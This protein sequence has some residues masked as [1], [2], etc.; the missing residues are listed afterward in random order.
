MDAALRSLVHAITAVDEAR[1]VAAL[2]AGASVAVTRGYSPLCHATLIGHEAIVLAVLQ[3]RPDVNAV[4]RHGN[5]ALH[6]AVMGRSVA[7]VLLLLRHG[8]SPNTKSAGGS[9]PLH[10]AARRGQTDIVSALL[11]HGALVNVRDRD[12]FTPLALAI[13]RGHL[14]VVHLLLRTEG[15]D[16]SSMSEAPLASAVKSRRLDIARAL[17]QHGA[18]ASAGKQPPLFYAVRAGDLDM[19][20]LLLEFGADARARTAHGFTLLHVAVHNNH[21]NIVAQLVKHG[22]LTECP[23]EATRSPD[24]QET[25]L[26]LARRL[27][28]N[29]IVCILE[30]VCV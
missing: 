25:L 19:V 22:A 20:S 8:A 5:V 27:G 26:A 9:T 10:C 13:T 24:E 7:L 14:E 30:P 16:I 2:D 3:R 28:L 12:A 1:V 23:H 17:L 11:D 29:D 15:I 21:A 4:D 6:Y 18:S